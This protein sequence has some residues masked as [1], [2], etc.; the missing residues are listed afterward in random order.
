MIDLTKT[1]RRKNQEVTDKG[2][3]KSKLGRKPKQ[4]MINWNLSVKKDLKIKFQK[5]LQRLDITN[6]DHI[7]NLLEL[8]DLRQF[9]DKR[10]YQKRILN[11]KVIV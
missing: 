3:V 11:A 2:S 8:V 4:G 10:D 1:G 6:S 5:E 7:I 9:K